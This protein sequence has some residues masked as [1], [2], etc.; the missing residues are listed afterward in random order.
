MFGS[1]LKFTRSQKNLIL[2]S[3]DLL[4]VP[5]AFCVAL[6]IQFSSLA[7]IEHLNRNWEALPALVGIAAVMLFVLGLWHV[8]L[9]EFQEK[10]V[11][12][13][14]ALAVSMGLASSAV[15]GVLELPFAPGFHPLFALVFLVVYLGA[16]RLMLQVLLAIYRRSAGVTR[17]A[18]YGAGRTGMALAQAL[19]QQPGIIAYAF[20]DDNATLDGLNVEGLPVYSGARVARVVKE[21][22]INRV[23]IAMPSLSTHKQ[24]YL[25]QRL[26][27]LRVEIQTL[28]A[29]ARLTGDDALLDKLTPAG[30]AAFLSRGHL[31]DEISGSLADYTGGSVLITGAGG[32]IGQELCRQI[33]RCR[34]RKLVLFDLSEL[35][36]YNIHSEIV[37]L[38]QE[39]GIELVAVLG[40]ITDE[41]L[42]EQVLAGHSIDAVLHAAAYK[43][44]PIVETNIRVGLANNALGTSVLVAKAHEA[45]VKRFVLVSSDKA[46]RPGNVMG[47]SK[48]FAE[49]IVQDMAA[50][51]TD[52]IFSIVRFGNVLGSSG[53]VIPLFQEQIARGGPVTLTDLN[54]T[55]YFMTI[56]EAARLVMVAGSFAE[57][58]EV[59]VLD[60]GQPVLIRDLAYRL[61]HAAGFSVRDELNP[62]G[63]IEVICTGLRPGEKLHEE[64][65]MGTGGQSTAH[66]KIIRVREHGL[67]ELEMA[68]SLRALRAAIAE[69]SEQGVLT[70]LARAVPEYHP[71][72]LPASALPVQVTSADKKRRS[73]VTDLPSE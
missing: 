5:I 59:Y 57:G 12:R 37:V 17:V 13:S 38:A 53:S 25:S 63:D 11:L 15:A 22:G 29:F 49:L 33:L 27:R 70:A 72:N 40:S 7:P 61:I 36:L 42:V 60:M 24:T 20:L 9:K 35:A 30:P 16:R 14:A 10:A 69:G 28:P 44:V 32:S 47:A 51:A 31:H 4:V 6:M 56:E 2:L 23:I 67:S 52:T 41:V 68:G 18:I 45:K 26:G 65:M 46:V 64:L 58:G 8:R 66:P 48:R 62:D 71:Q 55:R 43:H 54:V 39:A 3:A 1:I 73:R 34:P 21:Y 19:R 50:R